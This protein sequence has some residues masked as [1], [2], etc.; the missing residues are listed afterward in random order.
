MLQPTVHS[1]QDPASCVT[2]TPRHPVCAPPT[3]TSTPRCSPPA[4]LQVCKEPVS[5]LFQRQKTRKSPGTDGVSP[6]C[7]KTCADPLAP[8]FMKIFNTS[9]QFC[10]VPSIFKH[11]TVI[12]AA[13]RTP[14]TGRKD[15]RPIALMSVVM[16]YLEKLVLRH[17]SLPTRPPAVFLQAK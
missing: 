1:P 17:P 5:H 3:V 15:Y 7:I 2:C 6:S 12:P 16:K 13:K 8:I 9:M 4:A 14:I 11:S 10:K